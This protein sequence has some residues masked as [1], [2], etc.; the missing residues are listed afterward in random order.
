M[1]PE[2]VVDQLRYWL[3]QGC[4]IRSKAPLKRVFEPD[5]TDRWFGGLAVMWPTQSL[6]SY[7]KA[8]EQDIADGREDFGLLIDLFVFLLGYEPR[9]SR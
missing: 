1:I 5:D 9:G 4:T 7:L 6:P 8:H 2:A 3:K